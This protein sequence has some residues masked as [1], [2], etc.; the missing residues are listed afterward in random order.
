MMQHILITALLVISILI[1]FKVADRFNIIDKPNER[2]SHSQITI[3]GGGIVFYLSALFFFV[4]SGFQYPWFF[5][6]LTLIALISFL[7]DILTLSSKTRIIVQLIS[8]ILL[9]YDVHLITFPLWIVLIALILAIGIINAYN[10]MD[11]ING[12]TVANSLTVLILLAIS[13]AQINFVDQNFIYF[14]IASCFVF[15]FFNFRVRAKTFAGDVGAVSIAFIIL[16]LLA[17]LIIKTENIIYLLFLVIY[18]VDSVLTIVWRIIKK[19]NIFEA[20]RSHLYQILKNEN[21]SNSLLISG[22]YGVLQLIL[23]FGII[24]ITQFSLKIQL[25]FAITV[26]LISSLLYLYLKSTLIKRYNIR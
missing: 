3:R 11:G 14:V 20:H 2:S 19:E 12:I 24:Y 26:I 21:K 6:G 9:F 5:L 4:V 1:Y 15:A 25:I 8:M 18:G 17:L 22:V 10:F 13:N 7:D 16:F 23:G